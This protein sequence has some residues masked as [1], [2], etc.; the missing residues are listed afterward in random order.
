MCLSI[1]DKYSKIHVIFIKLNF[2]RNF[3][4]AILVISDICMTSVGER[5]RDFK[6]LIGNEFTSV[7]CT[8][9]AKIGSW[10]ECAHFSG[11]QLP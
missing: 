2:F 3:K 4:G 10:S 7:N 11:K 9:G 8:G 5:L 6:V 1:A